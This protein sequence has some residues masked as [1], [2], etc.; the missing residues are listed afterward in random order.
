MHAITT[1]DSR[2]IYRSVVR[3]ESLRKAFVLKIGDIFKEGSC[4]EMWD[5]FKPTCCLS[6]NIALYTYPVKASIDF[7]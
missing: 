3:N 4:A 7:V 2:Y 1:T 5:I 6:L